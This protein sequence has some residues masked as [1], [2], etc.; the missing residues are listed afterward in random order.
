MTG[1]GLLMFAAA[2]ALN[3]YHPHNQGI[4]DIT[5]GAI[6]KKLGVDNAS[7]SSLPAFGYVSPLAKV[8]TAPAPKL[9]DPTVQ[10]PSDQPGPNLTEAQPAGQ[11]DQLQA[12]SDQTSDSSDQSQGQAAAPV[13]SK[14]SQSKTDN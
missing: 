6:Y 12:S 2:V 5:H 13:Q 4:A 1:L 10:T 11:T 9:A 7:S 14:A 8:K 3:H